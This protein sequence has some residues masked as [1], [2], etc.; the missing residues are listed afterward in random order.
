MICQNRWNKQR[1]K[2]PI[3]LK[4]TIHKAPSEAF[5]P[6]LCLKTPVITE[7]VLSEAS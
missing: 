4:S 1:E 6:I 7:V 3:Q 5:V 2:H